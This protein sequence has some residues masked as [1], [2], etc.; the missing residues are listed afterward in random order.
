M[1]G[2]R[3]EHGPRQETFNYDQLKSEAKTTLRNLNNLK[4]INFDLTGNMWRYVWSINGKTLSEVDMIKIKKGEAVRITLNNFTMMHH[5]M[6]LHGHFFRVI[7]K[8]GE[9]SPL[10][11]TVDVAPMSSTTI[12]FDAN[13]D[14]DWFFHCHVLYHMKGGMARVFSYQ[15]PRDE[16][17]K[18]YKLSNIM[19]MDNHWFTWGRVQ[20]AS[21]MSS[22]EIITSNT[23]NQINLGAEYGYNKNLEADFSYERYLSEYL[24]GFI[25]LNSENKQ[26]DSIQKIETVGTIGM[27]WMLPYFIDT[28]VRIDTDLKLQFSLG[29]EYLILPR[30]M[31]FTR[32]E[33]AND[34]GW[35]KSL[36]TGKSWDQEYTWD[37]GLDYVLS[38]NF[39]LTASFDNRFGLGAGL[40]YL[41]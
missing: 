7:N 28:E 21:H 37:T 9:Y 30:T 32:L 14:G 33:V 36:S 8:N 6:H 12:E 40:I 34:W 41:W 26:K 2:M 23:R 38:K 15:T 24:R 18:N 16:R 17:L 29:T 3:H 35:K 27:R 13:E 19:D 20:A 22:F 25:G 11:H 31:L 5:P 10:K 4:Q 39:V 1:K